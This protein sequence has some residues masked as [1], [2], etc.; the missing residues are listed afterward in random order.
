MNIIILPVIVIIEADENINTENGSIIV[1]F[2]FTEVE[3]AI[4][5]EMKI[6][7]LSLL[8]KIITPA[9]GT[10]FFTGIFA[11]MV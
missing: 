6:K 7:S 1:M 11:R 5:R 9:P 4:R 3:T 8:K 10:I 2:I